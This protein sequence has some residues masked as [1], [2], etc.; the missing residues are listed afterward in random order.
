[1]I[2]LICFDGIVIPLIIIQTTPLYIEVDNTYNIL[3]NYMELLN[4]L[5]IKKIRENPTYT[6]IISLLRIIQENKID[7][8]LKVKGFTFFFQKRHD[9]LL[10]YLLGDAIDRLK[11]ESGEIREISNLITILTGS[12][13]D[14]Y[15]QS[16]L[17]R[18]KPYVEPYQ[19]CKVNKYHLTSFFYSEWLKYG[20]VEILKSDKKAKILNKDTFKKDGVVKIDIDGI[21]ISVPTDKLDFT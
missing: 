15:L 2:F 14:Q 20:L 17:K 12:N 1:M 10:E 6:S 19:N 8:G 16:Y 7:T 9:L 3:L 5:T 4:M 13:Y 11:H 21:N 18:L